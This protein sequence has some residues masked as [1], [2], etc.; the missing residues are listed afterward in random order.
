[1]IAYLQGTVLESREDS[2]V[3]V[4][5]G[6]G[7]EVNLPTSSATELVQGAEACFYI[8]E[9]ISPYDGTVLYGFAHKEDKELWYLFKTAIPNTGPK[10]ALEYLNKALRSVADFHHAIVTR[11][12]KILT[13]IFGFTAKTAEKLITSLKDKMDSVSIQGQTKIKVVDEAPYMSG[14]LEALSALGYSATESR[15][16]LEKLHTQG[17]KHT[18]KLENIVKEALRVLTK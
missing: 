8:A 13:S 7:Y 5:G 17:I 14:V 6:V 12:P 2:A 9:S 10:K 4:C 11:D 16:A 1:M 18:E 15:R 3:L